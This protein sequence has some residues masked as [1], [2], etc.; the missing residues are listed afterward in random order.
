M[1]DGLEQIG[2][3]VDNLINA[4]LKDFSKGKEYITKITTSRRQIREIRWNLL[5]QTYKIKFEY[6]EFHFFQTFIKAIC[7]AADEAEEMA[8]EI[9]ALICKYS[10]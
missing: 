10:L 1:A 2:V 5:S 6:I 7:N 3:E 9:Y 8:D 4:I